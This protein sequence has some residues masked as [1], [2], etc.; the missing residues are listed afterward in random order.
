MLSIDTR[1]TVGVANTGTSVYSPNSFRRSN[2]E[3]RSSRREWFWPGPC[4]FLSFL[5]G[6]LSRSIQ[7]WKKD[8]TC[9]LRWEFERSSLQS[10]QVPGSMDLVW[11][12]ASRISDC[13]T[14][15]LIENLSDSWIFGL[16][17]FSPNSTN[18]LG[19]TSFRNY[20]GGNQTEKSS[21]ACTVFRTKHFFIAK[22]ANIAF[23][24]PCVARIISRW[25]IQAPCFPLWFVRARRHRSMT[26]PLGPALTIA[27]PEPAFFTKER[28]LCH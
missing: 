13:R 12:L 8:K 28:K 20:V 22:N 2:F 24:G 11:S 9:Y 23:E 21:F 19:R 4:V 17:K 27:R 6:R 16:S 7:K 15:L 1:M 25:I 10:W 5:F 14:E 18:Q 26:M 3:R